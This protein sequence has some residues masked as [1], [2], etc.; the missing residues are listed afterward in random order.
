MG[1]AGGGGEEGEERDEKQAEHDFHCCDDN[2][3]VLEVYKRVFDAR[4]GKIVMGKMSDQSGQ[5][6]QAS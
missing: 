5:V 4:K 6:L 3:N 1:G 2:D